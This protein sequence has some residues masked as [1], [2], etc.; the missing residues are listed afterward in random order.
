MFVGNEMCEHRMPCRKTLHSRPLNAALLL[1]VLIP[2]LFAFYMSVLS[3]PSSDEIISAVE[4]KNRTKDSVIGIAKTSSIVDRERLFTQ[5]YNRLKEK[6]LRIASCPSHVVY[7]TYSGAGLCNLMRA[8]VSTVFVS[9]V[10]GRC[11]SSTFL[12][13]HSS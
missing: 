6:Q 10:T 5:W 3:L 4:Y 8:F 2:S 12:S 9:A 1:V 7:N 11:V 13:F